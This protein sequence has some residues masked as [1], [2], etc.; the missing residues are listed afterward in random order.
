MK[1]SIVSDAEGRLIGIAPVHE[2][3]RASAGEGPPLTGRMVAQE[4]QHL[5][6]LEV[7]EDF[8]ED[9][10]RLSRLHETHCIRDGRL[11]PVEGR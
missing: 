8:F 11:E 10:E 3:S 5:H 9:W 7:D 6:E 2:P 1:I 4:G